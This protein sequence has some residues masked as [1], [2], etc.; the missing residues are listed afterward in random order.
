MIHAAWGY[1]RGFLGSNRRSVDAPQWFRYSFRRTLL[2]ARFGNRSAASPQ[3]PPR[4]PSLGS[5]DL[6]R[7]AWHARRSLAPPRLVPVPLRC[8]FSPTHPTLFCAAPAAPLPPRPLSLLTSLLRLHVCPC[9][10]RCPLLPSRQSA[11]FPPV[12]PSSRLYLP[13][14]TR[15]CIL[16]PPPSLRCSPPS[17]PRAALPPTHCLE[18]NRR[19]A[20]SRSCSR[21]AE[22][23]D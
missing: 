6:S 16:N 9:P 5:V 4:L 21:S 2:S 8:R 19:F 23:T 14:R 10:C 15:S 3:E 13:L 18:R 22:P 17:V 1:P 20:G 12:R 7:V 11:R